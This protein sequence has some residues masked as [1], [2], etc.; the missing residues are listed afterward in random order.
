MF[1]KKS[2]KKQFKCIAFI[3]TGEGCGC[4][5][6][7]IATANFLQLLYRKR[8]ALIELNG[9]K[10]FAKI[11]ETYADSIY[12]KSEYDEEMYSIHR[13][14][15]YKNAGHEKFFDI[16][17]DTYEYMVLDIGDEI[18]RHREEIILSDIRCLIGNFT[19]WRIEENNQNLEKIQEIFPNM[20]FKR[21]VTFNG[22]QNMKMYKQ[23]PC[24]N[25]FRP[26]KKNFPFL[27]SIL[28]D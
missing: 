14:D 6:M 24:I 13:V 8:T 7:A 11:E 23:I 3:S 20:E 26:E 10:D 12:Q 5:H 16:Y 21:Y 25:S 9:S 22:G 1:R 27:M 28:E 4:T 15:Y 19:P 17:S 18:A 2:V